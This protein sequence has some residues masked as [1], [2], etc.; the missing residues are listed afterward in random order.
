MPSLGLPALL[1]RPLLVGGLGL[2]ATLALLGSAH[3]NPLDS[4][5]L[6]SAIALGSGIWWWRRDDST[7]AAPKPIAPPVVDRPRVE[8]ELAALASLIDTLA[9]E[10]ELVNGSALALDT[11]QTSLKGYRHDHQA[12]VSGLERQTLQIAIAGDPRTGKTTLLTLLR[13]GTAVD[14]SLSFAEVALAPTVTPD[15]LGYD[16]VLLLTDGDLTNSAF[17]LLRDRVIA[18]QGTVLV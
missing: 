6:L 11:L 13:D 15:W 8:A 7:P 10:S 16:G 9:Q 5:T 3:F 18:G 1:K 14:S 2:S 4:S 17:T 12:L